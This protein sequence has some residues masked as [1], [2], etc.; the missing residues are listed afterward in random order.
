MQGPAEPR[1]S[2]E[3][4]VPTYVRWG[5]QGPKRL[6]CH[7]VRIQHQT[8]EAGF[9]QNLLPPEWQSNYQ[10]SSLETPLSWSQDLWASHLTG[11][12]GLCRR[13]KLRP[14]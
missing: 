14:L 12:R 8:Q 6:S 5:H 3:C 4:A 10:T 7:L 1:S 11:Q 9:A 13:I 2:R